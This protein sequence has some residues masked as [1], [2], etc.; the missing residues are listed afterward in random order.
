MLLNSTLRV[1]VRSDAKNRPVALRG[2]N[3]EETIELQLNQEI[4]HRQVMNFKTLETL[5]NRFEFNLSQLMKEKHNPKVETS[6]YQSAAILG[7]PNSNKHGPNIQITKIE[8]AGEAGLQSE[9]VSM[10]SPN[11]R[12]ITLEQQHHSA[13]EPVKQFAADEVAEEHNSLKNL[14]D[15]LYEDRERQ[16]MLLRTRNDYKFGYSDKGL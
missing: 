14:I 7:S 9:K 8:A 3:L 1:P 12:D 4:D 13:C 6:S 2:R 11:M 5:S 15:Q 10:G 16:F